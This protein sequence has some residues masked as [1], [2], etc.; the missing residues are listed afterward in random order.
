MTITS[1]YIF[2]EKSLRDYCIGSDQ[3]IYRMPVVK[4]HGQR[5]G[6]Y[7]LKPLNN[8]GHECYVFF[9]EGKRKVVAATVIFNKM[10]KQNPTPKVL[11][12][13]IEVL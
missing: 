5:K 13:V 9:I 3:N 2:K 8:N 11:P 7:K 4:Q 6:I 12:L 10:I 1:E